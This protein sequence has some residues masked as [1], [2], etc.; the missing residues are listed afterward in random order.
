LRR[1]G[2]DFRIFHRINCEILAFK[3]TKENFALTKKCIAVL[4]KVTFG[5]NIKNGGTSLDSFFKASWPQLCLKNFRSFG[6]VQH[7]GKK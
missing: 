4:H 2:K 5:K 6:I 3:V 1:C 7:I